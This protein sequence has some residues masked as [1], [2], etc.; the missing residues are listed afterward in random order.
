M[1]YGDSGEVEETGVDGMGYQHRCRDSSLLW[2][3]S[4]RPEDVAVKPWDWRMGD[5]I[6]SVFGF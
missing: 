6:E 4:A 5:T 3:V 2:E 1:R